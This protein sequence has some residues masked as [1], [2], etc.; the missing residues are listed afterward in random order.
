MARDQ[1]GFRTYGLPVPRSSGPSLP[2]NPSDG[3]VLASLD[4]N[5]RFSLK[6]HHATST[7]HSGF[8][9]SVA[10][11]DSLVTADPGTPRSVPWGCLSGFTSFVRKTESLVC[12]AMEAHED[13]LQLL[14]AL[15]KTSFPLGERDL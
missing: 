11:L 13:T 10:M 6:F 3:E 1:T 5:F 7:E 4:E 14:E 9:S 15:T 2:W 8:A 12:A